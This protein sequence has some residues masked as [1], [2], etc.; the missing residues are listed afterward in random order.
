MSD[1]RPA[2]SSC[3]Q[4]L[5]AALEEIRD[6]ELAMFLILE[7]PTLPPSSATTAARRLLVRARA[8][9]FPTIGCRAV[10][11][12]L[13]RHLDG[14]LG[15]HPG[16]G[17]AVER[18]LAKLLRAG[19]STCERCWRPLPDRTTLEWWAAERRS[20]VWRAELLEEV[21]A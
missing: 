10:L 21:G 15:E 11:Y 16:F 17:D 14:L 8:T 1:A 5:E 7:D 6:L 12:A 2:T 20:A 3:E 18:R 19:E 4:D 13:E 9:V